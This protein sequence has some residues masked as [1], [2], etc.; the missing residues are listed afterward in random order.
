MNPAI[1]SSMEN[2][3]SKKFGVILAVGYVLWDA[4][5][6]QPEH[7]LIYL[8]M[9]CGMAVLY[10]GLELFDKYMEKK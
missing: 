9:L 2:L 10:S 3:A 7:S 6:K 4:S 5:E 8:S 1:A